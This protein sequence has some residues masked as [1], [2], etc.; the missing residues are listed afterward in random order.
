[1]GIKQSVGGI[2]AL[3]ADLMEIEGK[4]CICITDDMIYSALSGGQ[5]CNFKDFVIFP[6]ESVEME[7]V[8]RQESIIYVTGNA[9]VFVT[10]MAGSW[11]KSVQLK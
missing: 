8:R 1:M 2:Q 4:G 10:K 9:P 7:S 3:Y 5:R 11:S 6:K